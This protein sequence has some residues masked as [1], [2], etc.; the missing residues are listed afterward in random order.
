MDLT[1]YDVRSAADK[2][3]DLHLKSP[4]DGEPLMDGD[5][6][7]TV[8]VL[9]RD[10]AV[11][12]EARKA[13]DAALAKGD[14]DETERGLRVMCAAIIGWSGLDFE[15]GAFEF[16]PANVRVLLT[17]S[18]TDWIAEQIAPFSLSRRNYSKNMQAS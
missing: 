7:V 2:G 1:R 12:Q 4:F 18:R 9:G 3:A 8:K 16:S 14:I 6:P 15:G 17:D 10:A 11:V 13:A 5:K